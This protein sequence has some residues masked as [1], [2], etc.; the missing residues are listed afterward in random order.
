M[1]G[2]YK[3]FFPYVVFLIKYT[4]TNKYTYDPLNAFNNRMNNISDENKIDSRFKNVFFKTLN[5][6]SNKINASDILSIRYAWFSF[7][8]NYKS[9]KDASFYFKLID[10]ESQVTGDSRYISFKFLLNYI[11]RLHFI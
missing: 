1:C 9:T 7:R 6:I 5:N 4:H 8:L 11:F 2:K 10:L 3:F